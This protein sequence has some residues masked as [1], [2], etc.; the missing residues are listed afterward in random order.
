[1]RVLR[2]GTSQA[3][4]RVAIP[5]RRPD[6]ADFRNVGASAAQK[7]AQKKAKKNLTSD[8]MNRILPK[9]RPS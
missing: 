2:K 1:M 9:R 6:G 3:A 4:S 8:T 7:K 5:L